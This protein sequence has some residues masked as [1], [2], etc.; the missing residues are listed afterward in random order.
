MTHS[1]VISNLARRLRRIKVETVGR[2]VGGQLSVTEEGRIIV[3]V[4]HE[5]GF[6]VETHQET[7]RFAVR[8]HNAVRREAIVN[9]QGTTHNIIPCNVIG[10]CVKRGEPSRGTAQLSQNSQWH[11]PAMH[12]SSLVTLQNVATPGCL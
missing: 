2:R 11:Q 9:L 8:P 4:R 12:G 1:D 5:K 7:L 3:V 10:I 6:R